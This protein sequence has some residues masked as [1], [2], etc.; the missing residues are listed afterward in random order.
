MSA[1][2]NWDSIRALAR[3]VLEHGNPLELTEDT[4]VLLLRTALEVGISQQETEDA[5]RG[6]DTATTL[7]KEA[8]RRIN[9]GSD[10]ITRAL[11]RM[12]DLRDKGDLDGACQQM[13]DVLAVE[14][15]PLYRKQA[16][17]RLKELTQLSEVA[18]TGRVSADLPDRPQLAVLVHR[19]QQGHA[20]E[21]TDD[22]R[23]LLHRTAPTAGISEAETEETLKSPGGAESLMGMILSRFRDGRERITRALFRMTS[24]RD[25][26]D[27]EGARQQMRDVLAVEV[28]PQYRQMAEE[29]LAGLDRPPLES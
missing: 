14:V 19:V 28:V 7:L 20:L 9:D 13:R 26:G 22:L 4:R 15:V 3:R 17:K 27:L 24:L 16:D 1:K 8:M 11:R 10:R 25:A 2:I 6:V 23:A 18:A 29:N 12:S 21:L 5:L